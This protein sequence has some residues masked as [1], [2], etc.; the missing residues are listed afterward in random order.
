[1]QSQDV[2]AEIA[3]VHS[4]DGD[5]E[6][7]FR[8]EEIDVRL[9]RSGT[10]LL[11]GGARNAGIAA[12]RAPIVSFLADDCMA[13]PGW[14]RERLIAHDSGA[15]AVASALLCH[16]PRNPFALAAHLSLYV[17]RMPRAAPNMAL[18]YGASYA[19]VLFDEVG[20]FRED[21]ESGEDTEFHQRLAA[22]DQPIWRPQVRTVHIGSDTL[23]DLFTD[24]FRRG[25]RMAGAWA[26]LGAYDKATVARDAIQ[27][28]SHIVRQ[29]LDLVEP[30]HRWA[31]WLAVPL[32][33]CGNLA[34]ACGAWTWKATA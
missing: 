4:G 6:A 8:A 16:R 33:A 30:Q 26:A 17:R 5:V 1:V 34:Y 13:E 23:G 3:V 10:R 22:A 28:T 2:P 11:A 14:L 32:I 25:R 7:Y 29:S 21:L 27:R 9:V 24:Q 18:K 12:T 15:R 19:R 20:L 31:A